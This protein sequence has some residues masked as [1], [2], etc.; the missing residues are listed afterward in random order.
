MRRTDC[1]LIG[2]FL[3]LDF[4]HHQSLGGRG[5]IICHGDDA[6]D[7][8]GGDEGVDRGGDHGGDR[9]GDEGGNGGGGD[10]GQK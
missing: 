10:F 8:D 9:D 5:S 4:Q 6:G 3:R 1:E 7:D 2:R